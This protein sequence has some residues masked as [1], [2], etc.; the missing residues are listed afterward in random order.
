MSWLSPKRF[1]QA[2]RRHVVVHLAEGVSLDGILAGVYADGVMLEAAS[3]IRAN[4]YDTPL[5]GAQI[6]PWQNVLWIQELSDAP[7]R[8][9]APNA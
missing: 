7:V 1:R 9:G 5:D 6:I 3:Y 8:V 4:D 2:V